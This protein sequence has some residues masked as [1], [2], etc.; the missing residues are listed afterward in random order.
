MHLQT[1]TSVNTQGALHAITRSDLQCGLSLMQKK[2]ALMTNLL[3][4]TQVPGAG[5]G[6]Q[7]QQTPPGEWELG[8]N[9]ERTRR[10]ASMTSCSVA[11]LPENCSSV[12]RNSSR[13]CRYRAIASVAAQQ[14]TFCPVHEKDGQRHAYL[15]MCPH[16]RSWRH[17][18]LLLRDLPVELLP[19]RCSAKV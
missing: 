3:A 5:R 2:C 1:F 14:G 18:W 19:G 6:V 13:S 8:P 11:P 7:H 9:A 17:K 4:E 10:R 16:R 15:Y 12:A